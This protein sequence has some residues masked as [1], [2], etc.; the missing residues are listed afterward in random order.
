MKERDPNRKLDEIENDEEEEDEDEEKEEEEEEPEK[1]NISDEKPETETEQQP[2][3][4]PDLEKEPSSQ[5]DVDNQA[6]ITAPT[7]SEPVKSSAAPVEP[8]QQQLESTQQTQKPSEPVAQKPLCHSI[9]NES[10]KALKMEEGQPGLS[11]ESALSIKVPF[12]L[13]RKIKFADPPVKPLNKESFVEHIKTLN[14]HDVMRPLLFDNGIQPATDADDSLK[15]KINQ[16]FNA[17]KPTI[18]NPRDLLFAKAS[19]PGLKLE[20]ILKSKLAQ[21][22]AANSP[23]ASEAK[24]TAPTEVQAPILA[25]PS[26][27][28]TSVAFLIENQESAVETASSLALTNAAPLKRKL[29]SEE[30]GNEAKKTKPCE[31]DDEDGEIEEP[32]MLVTGV[33]SGKACDT[34]NET[35]NEKK[36]EPAPLNNAITNQLTHKVDDILKKGESENG[37]SASTSDETSHL[38]AAKSDTELTGEKKKPK[39]WTI[40]AICSSDS[41]ETKRS[42][43]IS[44]FPNYSFNR[45]SKKS[46]TSLFRSSGSGE[47]YSIFNLAA[48]SN[49]DHSMSMPTNFYFGCNNQN[50][51]F[52]PSERSPVNNFKPPNKSHNVKDFVDDLE[53]KESSHS[54]VGEVP[55]FNVE[56]LCSKTSVVNDIPITECVDIGSSNLTSAEVTGQLLNLNREFATSDKSEETLS[57]P[58]V[59]DVSRV[60]EL[61]PLENVCQTSEAKAADKISFESTAESSLAESESGGDFHSG[62]THDTSPITESETA[63]IEHESAISTGQA[64]FEPTD[65]VKQ[66][67]ESTSADVI[68]ENAE[69]IPNDEIQ[70]SSCTREFE[71]EPALKAVEEPS[72]TV[73]TDEKSCTPHKPVAAEPQ[74][75][76]VNEETNEKTDVDGVCTKLDAVKSPHPVPRVEEKPATNEVFDEPMHQSDQPSSPTSI[77]DIDET[78][79]A[80]GS[81]T[82]KREASLLAPLASSSVDSQIQDSNY[83]SVVEENSKQNVTNMPISCKS[84]NSSVE[85]DDVQSSS[86]K[87]AIETTEL[88]EEPSA[89][90]FSAETER[91]PEL[92]IEAASRPEPQST[93]EKLVT[94]TETTVSESADCIEFTTEPALEL[95][96]GGVDAKIESKDLVPEDTEQLQKI[97]T[98]EKVESTARSSSPQTGLA[99]DVVTLPTSDTPIKLPSKDEAANECYATAPPTHDG[100]R[101][102]MQLEEKTISSPKD[103]TSAQLFRKEGGSEES[104]VDEPKVASLD[105]VDK[106]YVEKSENTDESKSATETTE[107][108]TEVNE[109]E[110]DANICLAQPPE[111]TQEDQSVESAKVVAENEYVTESKPGAGKHQDSTS[112]NDDGVDVEQSADFS[113]KKSEQADLTETKAESN[114]SQPIIS[115]DSQE[116]VTPRPG[117][118]RRKSRRTEASRLLEENG[119]ASEESIESTPTKRTTR[120][121]QVFVDA[122]EDQGKGKSVKGGKSQSATPATESK[123]GGRGSQSVVTEKAATKEP[124]GKKGRG[125][126]S[127]E[128]TKDAEDS[129]KAQP[130]IETDDTETPAAKQPV[131]LKKK[132]GRAKKLSKLSFCFSHPALRDEVVINRV[133]LSLSF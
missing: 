35:D 132:R 85:E 107:K 94:A 90:V 28:A 5:P 87:S 109:S 17:I 96:P 62:T 34:G 41:K 58:V 66:A 4:E 119:P 69:P 77:T 13:R 51:C 9:K 79:P 98:D 118:G 38:P 112:E 33:G 49:E 64:V 122:D 95:P 115:D 67:T 117:P 92:L 99:N 46:E 32:M 20:Q 81:V 7:K 123:R 68:N 103:R 24:D 30:A 93:D 53:A 73:Q 82:D 131:A 108:L 106:A 88:A 45:D 110:P 29:S 37:E 114:E 23:T 130:P 12:D 63:T 113:Q 1:Q 55:K 2:L 42:D 121:S 16:K 127:S 52:L 126:A 6:K 128:E 25:S 100:S 97:Q 21:K 11:S 19:K 116:T 71:I 120:R 14:S 124:A 48:D 27:D 39:L 133:F 74:I 50:P 84:H 31:A 57:L 83:S 36:I 80:D 75:E 22:L 89:A 91:Q 54:G 111:S 3:I 76:A 10:K 43:D 59:A 15:L 70:G 102:D 8:S 129:E 125:K 78:K 105:D 86:A 26:K 101:S 61:A 40:D 18:S 104:E 47:S 44:S 60:A 72:E 56:S 65:E